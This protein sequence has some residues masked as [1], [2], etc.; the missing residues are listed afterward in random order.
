MQTLVYRKS[1]PDYL[2]EECSALQFR[3]TYEGELR[4]ATN[5]QPRAT[6]KHSI[7]KKLHWQLK[8]LWEIIPN[9]QALAAPVPHSTDPRERNGMI[10]YLAGDRPLGSYHFVPLVTEVLNL[11]C[12]IEIL[13]LRPS[14]PGRVFDSGDIDNRIKTLFDAFKRPTQLQDVGDYLSP[15]RGEDPFF[16]L[17]DDDSLVAK[18]TV[19]TDTLLEPLAGGIPDE[20]DARLIITVTLRP[21]TVT[22]KNLGF[23]G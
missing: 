5:R 7:R 3:L 20:A 18:L 15:E 9:L 19:E 11:W 17:L 21:A 4:P 10:S 2:S 14:P 12:G 1:D 13:F 16:C 23:A 8:R 22:I 6:H